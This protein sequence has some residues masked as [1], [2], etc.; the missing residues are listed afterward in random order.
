MQHVRPTVLAAATVAVLA[1][2][3]PA[4]A[5]T[6]GQP[7]GDLHPNVGTLLTDYDSASPG[8]ESFCS[9][10]LIAPRVVLTAAHCGGA[11]APGTTAVDVSFAPVFD[12]DAA[13]PDVFSG[14][15]VAHPDFGFSGPG[16]RSDPHDIAVVLLDKA[17]VG[18]RRRSCRLPACSTS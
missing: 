18:S 16:G 7:D 4:H 3:V 17:P 15:F 8:P 13:S 9:G 5:I 1:A 2:A 14:T 11:L 6:F 10:T 12:D